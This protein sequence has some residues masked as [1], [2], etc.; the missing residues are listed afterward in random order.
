MFLCHLTNLHRIPLFFVLSLLALVTAESHPFPEF[1]KNHVGRPIWA[2]AYQDTQNDSGADSAIIVITSLAIVA[3]IDSREGDVIWRLTSPPATKPIRPIA[4][5]SINDDN[6]LLL[7]YST[8]QLVCIDNN[9]GQ[10]V[11][12]TIACGFQVDSDRRS[13]IIL[14]CGSKTSHV[15]ISMDDGEN[16]NP[17]AYDGNHTVENVESL[18]M[19][20]DQLEWQFELLKISSDPDGKVSST[21]LKTQEILW[22]RE[23][24]LGHFQSAGLYTA[25]QRTHIIVLSQLGTIFSLSGEGNGTIQWKRMIQNSKPGSC[26]LISEYMASSIVICSDQTSRKTTIYNI[27]F[28]SGDE[29]YRMEVE[30]FV[31]ERAGIDRVSSEDK[32]NSSVVIRMLSNKGDEKCISSEQNSLFH[33]QL[34]RPWLRYSKGDSYL[35]AWAKGED[36]WK[37]IVPTGSVLVSVGEPQAFHSD[38][39]PFRPSP[40]R[41]TGD[42]KL[43]FHDVRPDIIMA[44]AWDKE[45]SLLHAMLIDGRTGAVY[46]TITHPEATEPISV[47]RGDSWFVY[48]FWSTIMLQQEVHVLDLYNKKYRGTWLKSALTDVATRFLGVGVMQNIS[49]TLGIDSSD[50]TCDSSHGEEVC[51]VSSAEDDSGRKIS[52]KPLESYTKNNG[53]PLMVRS[54]AF[55]SERIEALDVTRTKRGIAEPSIVM[56]IGSGQVVLVSK[57]LLDARRPKGEAFENTGEILLPYRPFISL[58]S[59]SRE[60]TKIGKGLSLYRATKTITSPHNRESMCEIAIF[61]TDMA[62][63]FVRPVKSFDTLPS[64]FSHAQVFFLTIVL[65]ILYLFSNMLQTKTIISRSWE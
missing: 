17:E 62:Y 16:L 44:L 8:N 2:T 19:N 45:E 63:S 59:T 10:I 5:E 4:A 56:M 35:R 64:D 47:I 28:S 58:K 9:R 11:W 46:D 34:S 55:L 20:P 51:R 37:I 39:A 53:P 14:Q 21:D 61:G 7:L 23:E 15:H 18:D 43:L 52:D 57:I 30:D 13:V 42:R 50:S 6:R 29:I 26:M 22:T 24:G 48:S 1:R 41:V 40:V 33:C 12:S 36:L 49:S 25:N 38:V 65:L 60:I 27:D 3:K 32:F 31:C 54:N